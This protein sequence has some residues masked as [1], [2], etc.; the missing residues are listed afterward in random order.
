MSLRSAAS[1][2]AGCLSPLDF[3]NVSA[4]LP[5]LW[6]S[7]PRRAASAEMRELPEA[8]LTADSLSL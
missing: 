5:G 6:T 3:A 2:R 7:G 1:F 8:I 4:D